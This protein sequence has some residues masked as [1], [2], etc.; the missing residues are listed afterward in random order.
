MRASA[1]FTTRSMGRDRGCVCSSNYRS[2][3]GFRCSTS[4][5][6]L[7]TQLAT[8][9]CGLVAG[10]PPTSDASKQGVTLLQSTRRKLFASGMS[11]QAVWGPSAADA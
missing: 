10:L 7:N 3:E 5:Y 9:L 6:H 2:T 1:A 4:T 11:Q 8:G